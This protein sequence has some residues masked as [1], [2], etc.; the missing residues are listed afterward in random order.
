MIQLYCVVDQ[1]EAA[2]GAC[3]SQSGP[4]LELIRTRRVSCI[5]RRCESTDLPTDGQALLDHDVL[6]RQMMEVS[7]VVPFRYGTVVPTVAEAERELL[8]RLKGHVE[9]ALRAR[10]STSQIRRSNGTGRSYLR[11]LRD[12]QESL[13]LADLHHTLA[14]HCAAAVV[15]AHRPCDIKASYL[16]ERTE[17]GGFRLLLAHTLT[18]RR[19][20]RDVSL[21][22]PWAPYSFVTQAAP[23]GSAPP[24][25]EVARA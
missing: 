10:A 11:M 22:G 15:A 18:G 19:G 24:E 7:T 20:L 9:L 21:T 4:D 25:R 1:P 23:T 6:V 2:L 5:G 14:S 16:V 13:L 3:R 12:E 17:V 8:D